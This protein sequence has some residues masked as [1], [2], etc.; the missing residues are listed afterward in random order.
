MRLSFRGRVLALSTSVALVGAIA[1]LSAA[2]PAK[3]NGNVATANPRVGH[4]STVLMPGFTLQ[5]IAEGS[6][7]LENPSGVITKFGLLSDGTRT[8]PDQNVYLEFPDNPG[9]PTD[10]FD[11]GTHFLYQGHE[12]AGDLAYVTRINMDVTDPAHHVTLLTPV[13]LDGKTHFNSMDGGTWN[14]FTRTLLFTQ[15]VSGI[16]G[17]VVEITPGWPANVRTLYGILGHGAY[18]GIHPDNRGNL[19][20]VE[21][22]GGPGVHV[23]P[24][25]P[26]SPTSAKQPNSFVYWFVPYDTGD[27]LAGG[28]LY[29][30]Q[31]TVDGTPITFHANDAV[32]D[33]FSDEQLK[34]HTSGTSWPAAWVL[35]HDTAA[36]GFDAFNANALAKSASASPFKRPENAAFLPGSGFNT[37]FFCPTGDTDTRS[38]S[39]PA[40]AAR[41]AWGSIFRADFTGNGGTVSILVLGDAVHSS[42]DNLTFADTSTIL[43]TE[44]RGDTLHQQL[45]TLD[46]VWAFDVRGAGTNPRRLLALGRDSVSETSGEDN[47][48]TGLFV[49]EGGISEDDLLG[50]HLNPQQVRWFVTQQHGMNQVWEIVH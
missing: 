13:G 29:A 31:V 43:A 38:G 40:L 36:D 47:E 24:D 19:L 33:T 8:E 5:P 28:Q 27:L 39:Q 4:P 1:S 10:G 42:F 7:P 11:Y 25:D 16:G 6:E 20:L 44:D 26:T 3:L 48:P 46:S 18:E 34:L 41:G 22:S 9:G 35:I 12:N 23:I 50:M 14:P 21:D 2:G 32:G 45:N 15:E 17:G 49:S 30:L 37:F